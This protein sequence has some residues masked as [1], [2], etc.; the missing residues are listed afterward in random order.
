MSS[1]QELLDGYDRFI[2]KK[3]P[4]FYFP[5]SLISMNTVIGDMR[6]LKGGR[7]YQFVGEKSTG[8]TSLALDIIANAQKQGFHCTY[9]DVERTFDE[10][11]SQSLGVNTDPSVFT[12]LKTDTAE[13]MFDIAMKLLQAGSK[14]FVID[15]IAEIVPQEE[16][17]KP[18]EDAARMA[19]SAGLITRALKRL[20]PILDNTGAICIIINQFRANISTMSRKTRKPFGAE[21]LEYKPSIIFELARIENDKDSAVVQVTVAKSKLGTEKLI[22]KLVTKYGK[23]FDIEHDILQLALQFGIVT[24]KGKG[25]YIYGETKA[26]GVDNAKRELPMQEIKEKVLECLTQ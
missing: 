18:I 7:F 23:G 16:A 21:I 15:S 20:T 6:G 2:N 12:H 11:Y 9:G 26:N 22:T 14:V 17:D 1:I 5:F 25:W 13:Q 10:V 19:G 4:E 3:T 8:K 24:M